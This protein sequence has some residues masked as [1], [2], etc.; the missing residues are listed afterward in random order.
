VNGEGRYTEAGFRALLQ[1]IVKSGSEKIAE[2][3]NKAIQNDGV[4]IYRDRVNFN[5]E[6]VIE[7]VF[8]RA[9]A[10]L[11]EILD[12]AE[13]NANWRKSEPNSIDELLAAIDNANETWKS[14]SEVANDNLPTTPFKALVSR[15][16]VKVFK[17]IEEL[18]TKINEVHT[19]AMNLSVKKPHSG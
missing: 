13:F 9:V 6:S 7:N 5:V 12:G 8:G 4:H 17:M 14:L 11:I 1:E 18:R 10:Q 15:K 3:L 16:N 2:A 19:A